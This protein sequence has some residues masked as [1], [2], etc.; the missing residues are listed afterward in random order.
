[1]ENRVSHFQGEL[2]SLKNILENVQ[3]NNH[4]SNN[5]NNDISN[6]NNNGNAVIANKENTKHN[7][8]SQCL[9]LID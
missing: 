2:I 1:M 6:G 3:Q 5:N 4:N 7:K 9:I 8:K